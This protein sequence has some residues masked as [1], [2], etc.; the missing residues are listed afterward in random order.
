[1]RT[2][3][4]ILC[5]AMLAACA[6]IPDH[7]HMDTFAEAFAIAWQEI[8]NPF[9]PEHL[10]EFVPTNICFLFISGT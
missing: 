7:V 2:V 4:S 9:P 6:G 3:I 10:V 8:D 1:M 5:A